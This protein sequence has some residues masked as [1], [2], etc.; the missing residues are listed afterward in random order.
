MPT[1]TG[2][3]RINLNGAINLAT[4]QVSV[5]EVDCINAQAVVAHLNEMI[6][7]IYLYNAVLKTL[8]FSGIKT[9]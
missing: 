5:L 7:P 1:N 4:K 2:R 3:K 8:F 9:L 6:T